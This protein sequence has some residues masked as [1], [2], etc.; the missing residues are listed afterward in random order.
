MRIIGLAGL[1]A[2]ALS[3]PV[4]ASGDVV[5]V[6]DA[7]GSMW[8][9]IDGVSK[10]EIA[11]DV[12]AG[13]VD[14]WSADTDLGLVAYGHRR[15]ADCGDIE[16]VIA[17]GP[18]DR[19]GFKQTVNQIV[20]NGRTPLSAAV[21][22]A[23]E[24]L[25]WRE[26]PA[27]VVLISDGL[28]N[29]EADPCAL[30][31]QLAEQGV[32]FTTHVIGFD[33]TREEHEQLACI[34]DNTGGVFLP[35]QNADELGDALSQVQSVIDLEPATRPAAEPAP[36]PDAL[37]GPIT[38]TAPGQVSIGAEF[39]VAWSETIDTSDYVSIVPMGSDEGEMENYLVVREDSEGVLT[40]PSAPGVYEVRYVLNEG[41]KTLGSATVEVTD[42]AVTL[43]APE[44]VVTGAEFDVAWSDTL[45][46]TDYVSIVPMGSDEGK[47]ENYLVVREDS[48]GLLT[49]PS[50]PGVYEVRYVL[51]EG[52]KTLGSAAIEV[53]APEVIVM[54]PDVVRAEAPV[55]VSWSAT[56]NASDYVSIVPMGADEGQID[57]Y[58]V[59]REASEGTLTAPTGTGLYEVRYI[60]NE[61]RRTLASLTLEVVAAEAPL[62]DGAGLNVPASAAPGAP[63]TIE[64]TAEVAGARIALAR[65]D[66][67]DFSW[68]EA[69][70]TDGLQALDITMPEEA[71]TYEIRFLD[72]AGQD[73]LGRAIVEVQ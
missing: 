73:V 26:N 72:I 4:S 52:R 47:L 35:A 22:H 11:R 20:P 60:L 59:V 63:V 19:A 56:V 23:A 37:G 33:L 40:A 70:S 71:G 36:E 6:Y 50:E 28:E 21:E 49:A 27:T 38:L 31:A 65:A 57:D 12:M 61:G 8:G 42:A 14:G 67:P 2:A 48:Q 34:A 69:H 7:S 43:T 30:S 64:W 66:Q 68:V 54:G 39:D 46:V 15:E 16:T 44:A 13:L 29:C 18:V 25:A 53:T 1:I 55:D 62:D 58:L 24:L 32:G 45:N 9:Q 51:N 17:P 10:I 3:V 41:R 5:V